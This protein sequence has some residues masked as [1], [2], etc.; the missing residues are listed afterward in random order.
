MSVESPTGDSTDLET[1]EEMTF[2]EAVES[3]LDELPDRFQ[4][5]SKTHVTQDYLILIPATTKFKSDDK[6]SSR[7]L[8]RKENRTIHEHGFTEYMTN[9]EKKGTGISFW[10]KY[11]S[12]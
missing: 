3:V 10:Y 11:D 7:L 8:S 6:V 5:F 1:T 4:Q 2:E 9:R 12:S